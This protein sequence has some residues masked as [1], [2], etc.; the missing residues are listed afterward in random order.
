MHLNVSLGEFCLMLSV[1][2][3]NLCEEEAFFALETKRQSSD[4]APSSG[5]PSNKP[6]AGKNHANPPFQ[7]NSAPSS[8]PPS[9]PYSI[10]PYGSVSYIDQLRNEAST[11]EVLVV[12]AMLSVDCAMDIGYF[13]DPPASIRFLD[14][15]GAAAMMHATAGASENAT[16]N[17]TNQTNPTR[18]RSNPMP[19][20]G[21]GGG[22]TSTPTWTRR[23]L[24]IAQVSLTNGILHTRGNEHTIQL[25]CSI[26]GSVTVMDTRSS[27]TNPTSVLK[28]ETPMDDWIASDAMPPR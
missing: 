7:P 5:V 10:P 14:P 16:T 2:F 23:A 28:A 20:A 13:P 11:W 24:P 27:T 1:W 4:D 21:G 19:V 3:D 6:A 18:Q 22:G 12:R 9:P 15:R 17:G 26:G 25:A 8:S